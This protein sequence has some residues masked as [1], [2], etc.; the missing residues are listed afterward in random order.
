[1]GAHL[2]I[3]V[4]CSRRQ[5]V[6]R[7]LDEDYGRSVRMYAHGSVYTEVK[8]QGV[9]VLAPYRLFCV[10]MYHVCTW[11]VYVCNVYKCSIGHGGKRLMQCKCIVNVSKCMALI[12]RRL[13]SVFLNFERATLIDGHSRIDWPRHIAEETSTPAG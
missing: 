11:V 8:H 4:P 10:H 9:I 6:S 7:L 12:N 2:I 13:V 3:T 1:M 5:D